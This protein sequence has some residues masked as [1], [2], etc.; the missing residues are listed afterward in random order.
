ME[1]NALSPD[2]PRAVFATAVS[3]AGTVIAGVTPDQLGLP[4]PC[5]DYD[6]QHLLA[7][8]VSVLGRVA[9]IGRQ[10][11][12]FMMADRIEAVAPDAWVSAWAAAA[13]DVQAA[14]ADDATLSRIVRLPWAELPGSAQLGG[15]TNEVAVHTWDLATATGQRPVWDD[16][17]VAVAFSA[18][19]QMLPDEHRPDVGVFDDA[20]AVGDD[21]APIER[22]VAWNGRQP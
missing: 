16:Q 4:T 21:A 7:H 18:I 12:P 2:D 22:L 10:E 20:V 8:M 15:Y 11:D 3:L 9:R 5:R 17:M 1:R 6:V 13:R 14:W 19:T